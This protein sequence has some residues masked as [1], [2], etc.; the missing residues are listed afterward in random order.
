[1]KTKKIIFLAAVLS[2][3]WSLAQFAKIVD[4]DGYVNIRK[5]A[6]A[7]SDIAGKVNSGEI[8]YV[9]DRDESSKNWLMVDY[10]VKNRDLIS[11]YVYNSRIRYIESYPRV[12]SV[13][14]NESKT[15]LA[16]KNIKVEIIAEPFS[17]KENKKYFSSSRRDMQLTDLYKG[18]PVWGT[19]GTIPRTHYKSITVKIGNSTVEIPA[20]ET[21]NLFNVNTEFTEC[22]F[23]SENETL[24]IS[25]VNS[26]GAGGYAVLFKIEKG[27]YKGKTVIMPF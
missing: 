15:V 19:D 2:F 7:K 18:K 20:A 4:K 26:D 24:Y 12:P 16:S 3:Q 27:K 1:M 6:D 13:S 25:M 11:G 14:V 21:E 9:Y 23:D 5:N 8:I 22:Y 10:P 17:Y